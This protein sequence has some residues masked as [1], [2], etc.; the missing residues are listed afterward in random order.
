MST[1]TYSNSNYQQQHTPQL[2]S[3]HQ[4]QSCSCGVQGGNPSNYQGGH[5]FNY[6][7]GNRSDYRG[8]Q[9]D[10]NQHQ[11]YPNRYNTYGRNYRSR[12]RSPYDY[13]S[14]GRGRYGQ[15]F[16][17]NQRYH[18]NR[19]YRAQQRQREPRYYM[20]NR[21]TRGRHR[22]NDRV[23]SFKNRREPRQMTLGN[24]W[25]QQHT[26]D[27]LPVTGLPQRRRSVTTT[28]A[29]NNVNS[30]QPF[31]VQSDQ[32]EQLPQRTTTS[33]FRRQQHR[34]RQQE[35]QQLLQDNNRFAALGD[36]EN[37]DDDDDRIENRV[38]QQQHQ[39][40]LKVNNTKKINKKARFYLAHKKLVDHFITDVPND[41]Y[42]LIQDNRTC[43]GT[44]QFLYDASPIYDQWIRAEEELEVW[45]HYRKLH[46]EQG[47]WANEII[48]RMKDRKDDLQIKQFVQKQIRQCESKIDN[49]Q[50]TITKIK[51]EFGEFYAQIASRRKYMKRPITAN[52][53]TTDSAAT[54]GISTSNLSNSRMSFDFDKMGEAIINYIKLHTMYVH[55]NCAARRQI[56]DAQSEE[57]KAF[58]DFKKIGEM[59]PYW[60]VHLMLK[61]KV[62][63]W[64][65]KQENVRIIEKRLQYN[66]MPKF[67][68]KSE[69]S[70][71][72]D[73][74]AFAAEEIQGI[75]NG[76][77]EIKNSFQAKAMEYYYHIAT[78]QSNNAKS[79][80]DIIMKNAKP[81]LFNPLR[82]IRDHDHDNDIQEEEN[83]YKAFEH[84]YELY[85]KRITLET[86]QVGYFLE[87]ERVEDTIDKELAPPRIDM[88]L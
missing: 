78:R 36:V 40:Q 54:A 48:R 26:T 50:A 62:K 28:N 45:K 43:D 75:Y 49:C 77:Q 11:Y 81:K 63:N 68:A 80:I 7:G 27:N 79:E 29:N 31:V 16:H 58:R 9:N 32:Q 23:L 64:G 2:L 66:L 17:F 61:P 10:Y 69:F 44:R 67:I 65:K 84:Y 53:T 12:S 38:E 20:N 14:R 52:P 18:Y 21:F 46:E 3:R 42:R 73:K 13:Y 83:S 8:Y 86:E 57:Y 33:S 76:M 70:F 41:M 60:N 56:A 1:N 87:E 35:Q 71:K 25:P 55:K 39:H 37:N 51:L 72:F 59:T 22:S 24:Y 30:T 47:F 82:I 19:N 15:G 85:L 34:Q 6:R 74:T 5:R 4:G 88:E